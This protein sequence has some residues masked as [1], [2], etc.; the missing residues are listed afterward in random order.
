MNKL[1]YVRGSVLLSLLIVL[2]LSACGTLSIEAEPVAPAVEEGDATAAETGP[3]AEPEREETDEP[4]E[5]VVAVEPEETSVEPEAGEAVDAE[6]T[7]EPAGDES[8]PAANVPSEIMTL[9]ETWSTYTNHQLGFSIN[10]P[11]TMM[12]FLGACRW[13]EAGESYRPEYAYVPVRIFEDENMVYIAGEYFHELGGETRETSADGGTRRR[14]AE[15]ESVDN[16]LALLQN[17]ERFHQHWALEVQEVTGDEALDA[18]IKARY[19]AGCNLGEKVPSA[20]DGVYDVSVLGDG[21]DLE[22]TECPLNF[23]TV[24]KYYPDG[25]KVIAWDTGQAYTFAADESFSVAYDQEM[26]DSFRFLTETGDEAA[27]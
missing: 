12:H 17:P 23:S 22:Q 27:E 10:F 7:E 8:E 15:C 21:K 18:F 2:L 3:V 5:T 24:V 20:Q 19:G 4:S 26:I 9:D 1:S 6:I 11:V 16:S 14:F 25:N 13:D